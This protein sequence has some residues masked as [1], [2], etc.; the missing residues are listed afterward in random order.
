MFQE[1]PDEGPGIRYQPTTP[2]YLIPGALLGTLRVLLRPFRGHLRLQE[3]SKTAPREFQE[4]PRRAL[5][6]GTNRTPL[7]PVVLISG[8]GLIGASFVPSR[9]RFGATSGSKKV[10]RGL[11]KGT[12]EGPERAASVITPRVLSMISLE[13]PTSPCQ[14][15][16]GLSWDPLGDFSG[17][18]WSLWALSEPR[19]L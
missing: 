6:S 3:G 10:P 8:G 17:P 15:L 7:P 18:S 16:M 4:G 2:W 9:G 5:E 13:L 19:V 14:E 11:Q 1:G 12:H